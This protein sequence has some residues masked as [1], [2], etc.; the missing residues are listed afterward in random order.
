MLLCNY[1]KIYMAVLC[2][3]G[4]IAPIYFNFC[5]RFLLRAIEPK[6][7]CQNKQHSN[8]FVSALTT[9]PPGD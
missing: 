6:K 4:Q 3:I 8:S 1:Q 2:L 7:N 5:K 9:I